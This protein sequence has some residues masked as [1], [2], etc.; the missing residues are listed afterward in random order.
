[1]RSRIRFWRLAANGSSGWWWVG[2][3]EK[4]Q[5]STKQWSLPLMDTF[6]IEKQI[7]RLVK[8]NYN[9]GKEVDL[10][11]WNMKGTRSWFSTDYGRREG[12]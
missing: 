10:Q 4:S 7:L 9:Y 12:R 8:C 2:R 3:S 5:D 6:R 1:M 11:S